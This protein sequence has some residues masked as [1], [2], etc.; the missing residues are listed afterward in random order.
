MIA[1][2]KDAPTR[3]LVLM[4]RERRRRMQ[5]GR[6]WRWGRGSLL[7]LRSASRCEFG[8]LL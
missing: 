6:G 2:R 4:V 8:Q 1:F 5:G 7:S 3:C